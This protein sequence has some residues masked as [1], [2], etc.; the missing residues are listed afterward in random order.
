M[1]GQLIV[2][3]GNRI[4]PTFLERITNYAQLSGIKEPIL[5]EKGMGVAD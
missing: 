2:A 4:S 5:V 1:D 3:A